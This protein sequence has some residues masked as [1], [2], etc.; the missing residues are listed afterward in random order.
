MCR[1]NGM[2]TWPC[3]NP[4]VQHDAQ[5]DAVCPYTRQMQF[6]PTRQMQFAFTRQMQSAPTRQM[7]FAPTTTPPCRQTDRQTARDR[8]CLSVGHAE[9]RSSRPP[10]AQGLQFA[11]ANP[12]PCK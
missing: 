10:D 9:C 5:A 1:G 7:Q 12:K 3:A 8:D 2:S 4:A 6:A 11:P